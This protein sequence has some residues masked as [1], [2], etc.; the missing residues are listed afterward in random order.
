MVFRIFITSDPKSVSNP[1][2]YKFELTIINV[3]KYLT[4]T[5]A[6]VYQQIESMGS[7]IVSLLSFVLLG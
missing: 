4:M 1:Y 6:N 3:K 7:I 5:I 2:I